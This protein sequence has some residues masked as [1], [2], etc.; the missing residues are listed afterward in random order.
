MLFT[1]LTVQYSARPSILWLMHF[2]IPL[3]TSFIISKQVRR[4]KE[5]LTRVLSTKPKQHIVHI[6]L[7]SSHIHKSIDAL[8]GSRC[9]PCH[10]RSGYSKRVCKRIN[11]APARQRLW[12]LSTSCLKC[13][14][15]MINW[16]YRSCQPAR[17]VIRNEGDPENN[18]MRRPVLVFL[19]SNKLCRSRW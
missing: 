7:S 8:E 19:F 17:R 10:N 18:L 12:C 1:R 9:L 3:S 5:T 14:R 2:V 6:S 13:H 4:K 16:T 11:E 15:D